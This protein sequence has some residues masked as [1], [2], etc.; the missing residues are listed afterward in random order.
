MQRLE[1]VVVLGASSVRG[2]AGA[3]LVE[4]LQSGP[5]SRRFSFLNAGRN[6]DTLARMLVRLPGLLA[7]HRPKRVLLF[8]GVNDAFRRLPESR[9]AD[10]LEDLVRLCRGRGTELVIC[11]PQPCGEDPVAPLAVLARAC[12]EICARSAVG[13][14]LRYVPI[15]G[16]LSEELARAR[17][18]SRKRA[19]SSLVLSSLVQRFV[20]RRS[21]AAIARS[22]GFL[23]H[24]DGIHLCPEGA[25][26]C[27]SAI[28]RVLMAPS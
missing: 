2:T 1:V 28:E 18:R 13:H 25:R 4:V 20:F 5:A 11:S 6:G 14:G 21:W 15:H 10:T 17:P 19:S 12:A 26:L 23:L 3:P 16:L 7:T 9:Y 27:A 22:H 8:P 24:T